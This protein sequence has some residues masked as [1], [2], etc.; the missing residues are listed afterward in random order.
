MV[1]Q[2]DRAE[3]SETALLRRI[4]KFAMT[5]G[6]TT[7]VSYVIWIL[8]LKLVGYAIATVLAWIAAVALG[9]V[10]N[11]RFTF[12]IA[13]PERRAADFGLFVVGALGQLAIGEVSY[14]VTIGRLGMAPTP[15]FLIT[16]VLN[17][18][19]G[20]FFLNFVTFRRVTVASPPASPRVVDRHQEGG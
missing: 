13:G 5:G 10:I 17:T 3:R 9:F 11:R 14:Y 12:G 7:A 19:F 4:V 2:H 18:S 6:L 1:L 20:F 15:A 8:L 16:L